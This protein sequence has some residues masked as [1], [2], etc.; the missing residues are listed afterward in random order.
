MEIDDNSHIYRREIFH[1]IGATRAPDDNKPDRE[2]GNSKLE[3]VKVINVCHDNTG[4]EC[5]R[6]G[7]ESFQ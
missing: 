5:V 3:R 7:I 1:F 6:N 2:R 4:A